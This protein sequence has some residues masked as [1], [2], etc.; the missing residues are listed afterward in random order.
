VAAAV[1]LRITRRRHADAPPS[2]QPDQGRSRSPVPDF[3]E[4]GP[5]QFKHT[6]VCR[7]TEIESGIARLRTRAAGLSEE[8]ESD[9]VDPPAAREL[10]ARATALDAEAE[11]L[12]QYLHSR[13]AR[14]APG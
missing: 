9:V 11:A 10:R 8:A 1:V 3:T 12:Q 13:Q 14:S 4:V 6:R 2:E 5:E 7:D